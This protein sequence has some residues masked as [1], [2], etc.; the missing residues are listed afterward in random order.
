MAQFSRRSLLSL[1]AAAIP[2]LAMTREP[3]R[4]QSVRRPTVVNGR[5]YLQ[6]DVF[7]DK[8]LAGNQ[9]AVFMET[10]GLIGGRN[11][12]H[13]ARDQILGVHVRPAG[14]SGRHGRAAADLRSRQRNAVCR[15][16]GDRL[17]VRAGR[18]RGDCRG[19]KRIYVRP[20]HRSHARRAGM[21]GRPAAVCVDDATEAGVR[22]HA[23]CAGPAGRGARPRCVGASARRAAAGSELRLG[24]LHGAAGVA[25]GGRSGGG[26]YR[27]RWRRSSKPRS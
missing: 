24:V 9:L 11:A 10:A 23:E 22:P 19:T 25:R 17:D 1:A 21:A 6:Y 4:A 2:S 14:R 15:P 8:P 12:G 27:A 5:R 13:D 16:S 18:R 20:G 26:R 7:T 3:S